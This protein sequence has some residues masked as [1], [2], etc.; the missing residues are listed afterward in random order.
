MR[1]QLSFAHKGL[2]DLG[3]KPDF[4]NILERRL[5]NKNTAGEYVAKLWHESYDGSA[6][7]AVLEVVSDI[8]EKTK[9]NSPIA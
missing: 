7:K 2:A 6:E 5:E 3:T 4:L 9:S 1:K 8:W